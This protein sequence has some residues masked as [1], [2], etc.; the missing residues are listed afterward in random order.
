MFVALNVVE[1]EDGAVTWRKLLD[2]TFK[3]YPVHGS[4]ESQVRS[5]DIFAGPPALLIRL[6]GLIQRSLHKRFLAKPHQDDVHGQAMQ[7]GGKS[8]FTPERRNLTKELQKGFL[9]KIFCFR[10]VPYH[11]QAERIHSPVMQSVDALKSLG[12]AL[13][14]PSDG[15][16]FA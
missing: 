11:P 6:G 13:L 3:I 12:V 1:H 5:S 2:C 16:R 10:R 8:R 7:P 4:R 14:C 9:R 15:L